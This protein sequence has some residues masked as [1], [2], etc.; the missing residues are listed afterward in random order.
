MFNLGLLFLH[1]FA[2]LSFC[3]VINLGFVSKKWP[4]LMS[5]LGEYVFFFPRLLEGK[6]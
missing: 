6:S 5:L 1:V 3:L 4:C 2:L